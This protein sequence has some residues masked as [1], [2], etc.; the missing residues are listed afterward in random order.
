[1]RAVQSSRQTH[2]LTH[3][4]AHALVGIHAG[5]GGERRAAR[6]GRCILAYDLP[7]RSV[8]EGVY[9]QLSMATNH[10]IDWS[11]FR[12]ISS[13]QTVTVVHAAG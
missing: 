6:V 9:E 1:M 4:H 7:S 10:G 13:G 3:C 5:H 2:A 8:V 12:P 11:S